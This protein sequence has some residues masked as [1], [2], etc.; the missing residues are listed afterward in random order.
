MPIGLNFLLVL[1]STIGT[2]FW[3]VKTWAD[4]QEK[5]RNQRNSHLNAIYVNPFLLACDV[6]QRKLYRLLVHNEI[7]MLKERVYFEGD[8]E[9]E[10]PYQEALEIIYTIVKFFGWSFYFLIYGS[11]TAD[12]KAIRMLSTISNLFA[13]TVQFPD[14]PFSF[15]H[16]KQQSLGQRFVRR[17]V[18]SKT[19]YPEFRSDTLYQFDREVMDSKNQ[20][21]HLYQDVRRSIDAL[22]AAKTSQEIPGKNRLIA[23]HNELVD[24]LNYIENEE[25][26]TLA[27]HPRKKVKLHKGMIITE[28]INK[29]KEKNL[30]G[31]LLTLSYFSDFVSVISS[32]PPTEPSSQGLFSVIHRIEGR[33]RIKMPAYIID[34]ANFEVIRSFILSIKGVESLELNEKANSLLVIH[35]SLITLEELESLLLSRLESL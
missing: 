7:E 19:D 1:A 29:P 33:L 32:P 5:E 27:Q 16:T 34:Q 25:R 21:G 12:W 30:A 4:Q 24:L 11:Y 28:E 13:E 10:V 23:I 6:L 3:T 17:V 14:D 20:Y 15:T 31:Q 26:F 8:D 35:N 2:A 18:N 9:S 22:L